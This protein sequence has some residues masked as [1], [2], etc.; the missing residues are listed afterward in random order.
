MTI[1]NN[2]KA[3]AGIKVKLEAY[4]PNN[5][6]VSNN[7]SLIKGQV[8]PL[9]I[10][11][12]STTNQALGNLPPIVFEKS[13]NITFLNEKGSPIP[14]I[15]LPSGDKQSSGIVYLSVENQDGKPINDKDSITFTMTANTSI[16]NNIDVQ[17]VARTINL[18]SLI[19]TIGKEKSYLEAP[20]IAN[21]PPNGKIYSPVT[22]TLM[23]SSGRIPNAYI[24]ITDFRSESRLDS[25]DFYSN[26]EKPTQ[27]KQQKFISTKGIWISSDSQG[28]VQFNIYPQNSLSI[29]LELGAMVTGVTQTPKAANTPLFIANTQPVSIFDSIHWPNI[30]GYFNGPLI[31]NGNTDFYVAV[32][33][34]DN[35]RQG[36]YILFFTKKD[37][38]TN[39][40]FTGHYYR[41]QDPITELGLNNYSFTL[42]YD[43]FDL[44]IQTDFSYMAIFESGSGSKSSA[45][46]PLAY[47]GGAIYRPKINVTR[48]YD[49]C[50]L[51]TSTYKDPTQEKHRIP[52]GATIGID[53]IKA[54][55]SNIGIPNSGLF[56]EILGKNNSTTNVPL[57]TKVTLNMYIESTSINKK[58]PFS[59]TVPLKLDTGREY[60]TT[61]INIDIQKITNIAP[62]P[63]TGAVPTIWFDYTFSIGEDIYYS[64]LWKGNIDTRPE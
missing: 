2:K 47:Q 36:D 5:V 63:V 4:L 14:Q 3:D 25:V 18:D 11:L 49:A 7:V 27:I 34:Y 44:N 22:T 8:I 28:E 42:P 48:N 17:W 9:V 38:D 13:K 58:V 50:N 33:E 45:S 6:A 59:A 55:P 12:T 39:N 64:K 46:L 56:I 60:A 23:G 29:V 19:L 30:A 57:G 53:N 61:L 24:F 40:V 1:E 37:K 26:L 52:N 10:T 43:I 54:Y 31:S 20:T 32:E 16:I 15:Q 51:Y 62:D 35:A 21:I 41:V